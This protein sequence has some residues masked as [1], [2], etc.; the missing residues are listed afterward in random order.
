[1]NEVIETSK[2]LGLF[3]AEIIIA[4]FFCKKYILFIALP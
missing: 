1:M 4:L 2:E 3:I